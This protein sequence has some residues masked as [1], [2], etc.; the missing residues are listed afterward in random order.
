MN[1]NEDIYALVGCFEAI[2]V[3]AML[4]SKREAN[5]KMGCNCDI[6]FLKSKGCTLHC[7]FCI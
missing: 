4:M 7:N 5:S 3:C 1:A 6:T 2:A